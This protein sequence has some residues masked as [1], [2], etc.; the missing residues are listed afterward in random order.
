MASVAGR[1]VTDE[2]VIAKATDLAKALKTGESVN[3]RDVIEQASEI[4]DLASLQVQELKDTAKAFVETIPNINELAATVTNAQLPVD[5]IKATSP[6]LFGL[7]VPPPQ[8]PPRFLTVATF[9]RSMVFPIAVAATFGAFA[10][11]ASV[12]ALVA[13]PF[14]ASILLFLLPFLALPLVLIMHRR[15]RTTAQAA[16]RARAL[17]LADAAETSWEDAPGAFFST[18]SETSRARRVRAAEAILADIESRGV[19]MNDAAPFNAYV[20]SVNGLAIYGCG[21]L[22]ATHVGAL[23]ALERHGLSYDRI[24]TFA[25]VSA[26]SVVVA[27]LAVGCHAEQIQQLVLRLDFASLVRPELGSLPWRANFLIS[28]SGCKPRVGRRDAPARAG[29]G[30][31]RAR[32]RGARRRGTRAH[33]QLRHHPRRGVVD[34]RQGLILIAAELDPERSGG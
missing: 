31:I 17:D 26:G 34:G 9:L 13:L 24:E 32:P 33:R 3:L 27:M 1:A 30:L 28:V 6:W 16:E 7:F 20:Q 14:V 10:V 21:V 18:R 23:R 22:A 8:W 29:P 25:G 5:V 2:N 4:K 12:C 19:G 11:G 15:T